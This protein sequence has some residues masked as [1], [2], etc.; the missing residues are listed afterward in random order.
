MPKHCWRA[1]LDPGK[2]CCI[3][4]CKRNTLAALCCELPLRIAA[5]TMQ[6]GALRLCCMSLPIPPAGPICIAIPALLGSLRGG[7]VRGGSCCW[8]A[9]LVG[10]LLLGQHC[11]HLRVH[12]RAQ[13]ININYAYTV[14]VLVIEE[15]GSQ[16]A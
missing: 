14:T 11:C 13:L 16:Q 9:L 5:P 2:L 1:G 15:A 3:F 10:L 8:G 4:Q 7:R 6:D 12:G